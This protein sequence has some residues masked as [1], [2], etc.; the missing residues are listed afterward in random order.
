MKRFI[1]ALTFLLGTSSVVA[2]QYNPGKEN[3]PGL[4]GV[5]LVV[6]F[7]RAGALPDEAQRSEVLK[8]LEDDTKAKLKEAGIP[9]SQ[10]RFVDE[11]DKAGNPRL[12]V[13]V[14]LDKLNG[15]VPAILTE[16]KLLQKV[17]LVRDPSIETNAV[18]WS[19]YGVGNK[20]EISRIRRLVASLIDSFIEDYLSVNP[21]QSAS[22]GKNNSQET[23]R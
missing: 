9:F 23:K 20:L 2:A 22:S 21:K 3:L 1:L 18:T 16:V 12:I 6:M 15:F 14:T 7:G 5:R 13:M 10:S 8:T 4:I 11:I 17:H 19:R